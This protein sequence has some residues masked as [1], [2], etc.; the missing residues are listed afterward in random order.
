MKIDKILQDYSHTRVP[1]DKT[2]SLFHLFMIIFAGVIN[3]MV[4]M[5]SQSIFSATTLTEGTIAIAL[6]YFIVFLLMIGMSYI[7]G[8]TRMTTANI[9]RITFGEVGGKFFA[10]LLGSVFIIW[11]GIAIDFFGT[12]LGAMLKSGFN[13]DFPIKFITFVSGI[14]MMASAIVGFKGLDKIS[15]VFS[16]FMILII[17][18]ITYKVFSQ[19][20]VMEV[21]SVN[22]IPTLTISQIIAIAVGGCAPGIVSPPDITRFAKDGKHGVCVYGFCSIM[23]FLV[24]LFFAVL[25]KGVQQSSYEGLIAFLDI[26]FLGIIFLIMATWTSNDNSLYSGSLNFSVLFVKISKWKLATILGF[27]GIAMGMTQIFKY[28]I[29]LLNVI[30][31]VFVPIASV[32]IADFFLIDKSKYLDDDYNITQMNLIAGISWLIPVTVIV[33]MNIPLGTNFYYSLTTIPALDGFIFSF[34]IYVI[35]QCLSFIIKQK[36][37]AKIKGV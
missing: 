4:F 18:F 24:V 25:L 5:L 13:V 9:I 33:F 1:Q 35:L 17:A 19:E 2:K 20:N 14:F 37:L 32:I 8:K 16:P 34:V 30:G 29:P 11:F 31:I 6:G 3:V 7:G 27:F 23:C 10:L 12:S 15:V 21:L 26:G 28:F 22:V 36:K